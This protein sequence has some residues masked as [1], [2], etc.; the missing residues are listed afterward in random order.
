M[1]RLDW[2]YAHVDEIVKQRARGNAYLQGMATKLTAAYSAGDELFIA[3]VGSPLAYVFL[4]GHLLHL[5]NEEDPADRA[6]PPRPRLVTDANGDLPRILGEA[7]GGSGDILVEV[8]RHQLHDGDI[9]LLCSESLIAA[10]ELEQI[11]NMLSERRRPTD[12]CRRLVDAALDARSLDTVT[13]L[14][15]EY[16]IPGRYS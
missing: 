4:D 10:M 12:A 3:H 9:L 1:E 14:L 5:A 7:I 15:A 13:V 2:S 8:G 16:R 11:A 6:K